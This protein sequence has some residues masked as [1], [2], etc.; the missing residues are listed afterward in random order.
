[1]KTE[2]FAEP[3]TLDEIKCHELSNDDAPAIYVGTYG[4]YNSGSIF[5]QW[6]DLTTFD[7]D[8][9]LRE[10][11]E[12]LHADEEDPEFMVQDYMNIPEHLYCESGLPDFDKLELIKE[13]ADLDDDEREAY[14]KCVY[15][16]GNNITVEDFRERYCGYYDS[17]ADFAEELFTDSGQLNNV[18]EWA[19]NNINWD[20]V[21]EYI[22]VDYCEQD[23]YF[24][25]YC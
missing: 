2:L 15:C 22:N 11:C 23:H 12:R 1:M 18:P 9:E 21:W 14:E 3:L 8:D 19:K 4:K 6:L 5:G 13:I 10:Y 25:R 7:D 24:F 16:F 20:D 17:R